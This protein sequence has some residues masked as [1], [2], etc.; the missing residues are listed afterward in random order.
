MADELKSYP[1]TLRRRQQLRE[2]GDVA[3]SGVLT[4]AVVVGITAVLAAAFAEHAITRL[5][6]F[7][8]F[9]L[10]TAGS[11][12]S[13][14]RAAA[15]ATGTLLWATVPVAG[16]ALLV[17]L[18]AQGLQTGFLWAPKGISPALP[19]G[20]LARMLRD[21][22]GAH[23]LALVAQAGLV[24]AGTAAVLYRGVCGIVADPVAFAGATPTAVAHAVGSASMNVLLGTCC[25]LLVVGGLDALHQWWSRER[26]IRMS[27]REILAELRELEAHPAIRGR[28]AREAR[29][30]RHGA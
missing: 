28:R 14:K 29:R 27:R 7:V 21:A 1:A 30:L 16:V 10:G 24:A 17:S 5:A 19:R 13:L 23:G 15:E 4:G 8:R 20:G 9:A 25:V 6:D 3:C 11:P 22:V 18:V 2:A 12:A 26:R